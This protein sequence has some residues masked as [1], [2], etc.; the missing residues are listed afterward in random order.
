M[1][2]PA[3]G[4][5]GNAAV[6]TSP[7]LTQDDLARACIQAAELASREHL[8]DAETL[9]RSLLGR[10]DC[11]AEGLA[12]VLEAQQDAADEEKTETRT[13]AA[14]DKRVQKIRA[15]EREG[16][17]DEAHKQLQALVSDFPARDIPEDLREPTQ[18]LGGWRQTLGRLGPPI[19]TALEVL[20]LALGLLVAY[21]VVRFFAR[22]LKKR[23]ELAG[24]D[25][26]EDKV[27]TQSLPS[28]LNDHLGRL[29]EQGCTPQL[30]AQS[31]VDADFD[32]PDTVVSAAP[33]ANLVAS[34][35]A[36]IDKLVPRN[37]IDVKGTIRPVDPLRGAG[38]TI[39][40]NGRDGRSTAQETIWESDYLLT[41][42]GDKLEKDLAF[43][44]ARLLAPAVVWLA[45][46]REL[47]FKAS[48]APLGTTSW[49][50]YALFAAGEIAQRE[51]RRDD[52]RRAFERALDHDP[53]NLGARLNL[54]SLLLQPVPGPD[55]Y[56]TETAAAETERIQAARNLIERVN[57][58]ADDWST[59]LP[60]RSRYLAAIADLYASEPDHANG[61]IN[62]LRDK[63]RGHSDSD[64]L[65]PLL[66]KLRPAVDALELSATVELDGTPDFSKLE[67]EWRP[68]ATEYNIACVYNRW[69]ARPSA[70]PEQQHERRAKALERLKIA[71]DR[72]PDIRS[73]AKLDP[74]LRSIRK[75][76]RFEKQWDDLVKEAPP[77]APTTDAPKRGDHLGELLRE[78]LTSA[79]TRGGSPDTT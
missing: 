3:H 18:Q 47:D 53:A 9:Y 61:H 43:R 30:M 67:K 54:G 64:R 25:G 29:N 66:G 41:P 51:N 12:G 23:V 58:K 21:L 36:A 33:Q 69:A 62:V 77:P 16:F 78:L 79:I 4:Q 38:L 45:Y 71:I 17:D 65:T 2:A 56:P 55:G 24:F 14:F 59:P 19:V 75:D 32:L 52:A 5:G 15:L 27:L 44:Y 60:Y 39:S 50:S 6:G 72:V 28:A 57:S 68:V 49:R 37:V 42:K 1:V 8:K 11:A 34:L 35:L 10:A 46:R 76:K 48:A 31:A 74:A 40:L 22:R 13:E 26:S 20:A 70:T 63:I 73:R 7:V